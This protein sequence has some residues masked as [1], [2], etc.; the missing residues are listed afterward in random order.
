MKERMPHLTP[1]QQPEFKPRAH[2]WLVVHFN[3]IRYQIR[4]F[5][6]LFFS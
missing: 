3:N 4:F 2:L 1:Q 6:V 5:H